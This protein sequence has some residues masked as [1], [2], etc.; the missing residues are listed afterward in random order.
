[1][2]LHVTPDSQRAHSLVE[3]AEQTLQRLKTTDTAR[4][5]SDTLKDYYD[6][7]HRHLDAIA[8]LE[9]TKFK[10]D[11]AHAELIEY[12]CKTRALNEMTRLFLQE[13]REFR[14][15][16]QYEGFA[17]TQE[18]IAR[19]AV[20]IETILRTLR[21]IYRGTEDQHRPATRR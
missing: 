19:N 10:G 20:R 1:M 5:P 6:V 14:N 8:A 17:V 12:V 16:I 7:I 4:Y 21:T 13:L 2:K 15:R 11:G 3:S 18:Y 9:G